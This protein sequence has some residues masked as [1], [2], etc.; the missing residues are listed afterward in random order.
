MSKDF[1]YWKKQIDSAKDACKKYFK[2]AEDCEKDYSATDKNYNIFYSNVQTLDSNLC[3]NDPKPDIQ[4][5]FLKRLDSDKLKSNTYAEVARILSGAVEYVV[6]VSH[7]NAII[8]KDVHNTDVVGRGVAWIEYNPTIETDENGEEHIAFRDIHLSSLKYDEYLC[9]SAECEADVWWKARRHLLTRKDIYQRFG[10]SADDSELQYTPDNGKDNDTIL[11]RGEVWEI[12]DK[13]D[14]KRIYI[15]MNHKNHELLEETDD[16]YRLESFF[17]CDEL[18]FIR[19]NNSIVPVPELLVY[20]KQ[21][22]LLETICKRIAQI[23]DALKYVVIMGSQDKSVGQD[24][25]RAQNGDVLSIQSNDA[26]GGVSS[27]IT[28]VPTDPAVKT[29]E[30]LEAE[31]EKVKQNIYDITGIS[32]L[33]RGMS[34]PR[35]TAKAQQIKGLFGSLRFQDRQKCVQEHRKRIYRI[36]AEIIAEHYDEATLSEMTCTYLPTADEKTGTDAQI[37][38]LQAQG[39]EVPQQLIDKYNEIVNIPTW[40]DV[41]LIL[42]SDRLRNYTVDVETTAT[43]FDDQEQQQEAIDKLTQ[44]Y[45]GMA[46]LAEQLS[47]ELIKGFIPIIRMN[48]STCK[49]S[50]SIS[51][52]LE[53]ALDAAYRSVE[54]ESKQ[55][56]Q[57]TPEQQKLQADMQLQSAKLESEKQ[58]ALLDQQVELKRLAIEHD[59]VMGEARY[60][61][62]EIAIKKQEA[63]RKEAELQAQIY[64]EQE[65]LENDADIEVNVAGDVKDIA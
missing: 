62:A 8:K 23:S 13:N 57:P 58:R 37:Q 59:K 20:R 64:L 5:R 49:L 41:I 51:R 2:N 56:P 31:K 25:V 17:P 11:K 53:E 28:V 10:Y 40:E 61:E 1:Q 50:S 4:R 36:I 54:E 16:P 52:Q 32:D 27:M 35:E 42:R 38:L 9:S 39:K 47:P 6:D 7:V 26:P 65:K 21:A 63:D 44:T 12:W 14:K 45:I 29:I 19:E 33:M 15:L 34:D 22:L 43:A 48:L 3:L 60:K 18:S 55:P 46:Q 30:Y 24:I